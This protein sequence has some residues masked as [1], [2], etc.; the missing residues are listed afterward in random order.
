MNPAAQTVS[1]LFD[2]ELRATG[3]L[4][5]EVHCHGFGPVDFSDLGALD[6]D[7]LEAAASPR[8]SASFPP[9]T[10]IATASMPSRR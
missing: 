3:Q 1:D 10:S 9:F 6:L 8:A 5:V 7:R 4:P 2:P